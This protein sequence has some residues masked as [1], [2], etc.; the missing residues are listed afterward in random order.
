MPIRTIPGS[1]TGLNYTNP[2]AVDFAGNIAVISGDLL[3]NPQ[4]PTAIRVFSPGKNDGPNQV[5]SGPA[6][7]FIEASDVSFDAAGNLYVV[8]M[9]NA[10]SNFSY[11]YE[12]LEFAAGASG[13]IVPIRTL[14]LSKN[15]V[16]YPPQFD[17]AGNMYFS[18]PINDNGGMVISVYAPRAS[19]TDAPMRTITLTDSQ[20][21]E[22]GYSFRDVPIQVSAA[23]DIFLAAYYGDSTVAW[24]LVH[25]LPGATGVAAPPIKIDPVQLNSNASFTGEVTLH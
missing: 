23:G 17:G 8:H 1:M 11:F 19:G 16:V 15:D 2:V 24:T 4:I 7:G 20:P 12:M 25:Y 6:T 13:N 14:N 21:G 18:Y 5:I 9:Q 10:S 22:T 3:A